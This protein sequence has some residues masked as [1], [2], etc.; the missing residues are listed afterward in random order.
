MASKERGRT[1]EDAAEEAV[2]HQSLTAEVLED[3]V[4][5]RWD[6]QRHLALDFSSPLFCLETLTG[7]DGGLLNPRLNISNLLTLDISYNALTE[8]DSVLSVQNGFKRLRTLKA[9]HNSIARADLE[10]P[11]LLSLD[12]SANQLQRLPRFEGIR[13]VQEL[14]LSRN[15]ISDSQL[16]SLMLLG[17]LHSLDLSYNNIGTLPSNFVRELNQLGYLTKL[18]KVDFRGNNCSA[19]FP[20]Y[21]T[22]LVANALE[23]GLHFQEIDGETI[24]PRAAKEI[25]ATVA[26]VLSKLDHFD[27]IYVERQEAA[28]S[29][30]Q[31][32]KY[33]IKASLAGEEGEASIHRLVALLESLIKVSPEEAPEVGAT[34]Y[35]VCCR[36]HAMDDAARIS[37]FWKNTAASE[38]AKNKA[39]RE[40]VQHA[41]LAV[42]HSEEARPLILRGIANLC[43]IP[44]GSVGYEVSVALSRLARQEFASQA[45]GDCG[46]QAAEVIAEIV[47]PSLMEVSGDE[48]VVMEVLTGLVAGTE[49]L[50]VALALSSCVP[51]LADLLTLCGPTASLCKVIAQVCLAEENC[52]EATGQGIPQLLCHRILEDKVP[53]D[54]Q[55][56][57]LFCDMC[58]IMGRCSWHSKKAALHLTKANMHTQIL[59]PLLREL[60]GER[61]DTCRLRI[62]QAK[63]AGAVIGALTGMIRNCEEAMNTCCNNYHLVDLLL[64]AVKEDAADPIILA[65]SCVGVRVILEN[66]VQR[67]EL[68]RYVTEELQGF[69]SLLQYLG[70]TRYVG[71]C[72]RAEL[73]LRDQDKLS[74]TPE[75][76][77]MHLGFQADNFMCVLV[78]SLA[79]ALFEAHREV[80]IVNVLA[81]KN[82]EVLFSAVECLN[83]I[84]VRFITSQTVTHLV[85]VLRRL[86]YPHTGL[87]S[88]VLQAVVRLLARLAA[89]DSPQAAGVLWGQRAEVTVTA[90]V[91]VIYKNLSTAR[92]PAR[93]STVE[94][95]HRLSKACI[96]LL[97]SASLVDSVRDIMRTKGV[98]SLF[99]PVLECEEKLATHPDGFD[100][101]LERTWTGRDVSILV[102]C[103]SGLNKLNVKKKVAFRV[104]C[105]LADIIEGWPDT[106]DVGKDMGLRALCGRE[107][108]MWDDVA[109]SR[110]LLSL[111]ERED[112]ERAPQQVDFVRLCV[113]ERLSLLLTPLVCKTTTHRHARQRALKQ[114]AEY[115]AGRLKADIE[116]AE[117]EIAR[118]EEEEAV[119]DDEDAA[120]LQQPQQRSQLRAMARGKP[121]TWKERLRNRNQAQQ[122]QRTAKAAP[123]KKTLDEELAEDPAYEDL[124]GTE[125]NVPSGRERLMQTLMTTDLDVDPN[126]AA[127]YLN[128]TIDM[129]GDEGLWA[130][131]HGAELQPC[132]VIAASL[133]VL[134]AAI[135]YPAD[136][137]IR[138]DTVRICRRIN[139]LRSFIALVEAVPFVA[140]NVAAKFCRLM[141]RVLQMEPHQQASLKE[142]LL[143]TRQ[144]M[145]P[146]HHL[147]RQAT[148]RPL[149]KKEQLL[150]V[151]L[152]GLYATIA[153]QIPYIKFSVERE[154]QDW[155]VEKAYERIFPSNVVQMFVAMLIMDLAIDSG[156]SHG[157]YVSHLMA[158]LGFQREKMRID[159]ICILAMLMQHCPDGLSYD[160]IEAL[161][162]ARVFLHH[163]IRPSVFY[164]LLDLTNTQYFRRTLE[165]LLSAHA[166]AAE[167]V[168][169]VAPV[170]WWN[171]L[172]HQDVEPVHHMAVATN[173]RF[174]IV[175]KPR[176]LREPLAPETEYA[177]E[178]GQG[179]KIVEIRDY[180]RMTR[181]VKGFP[182]DEWLAVGWIHKEG[183]SRVGQEIFDCLLCEVLHQADDMI[184]CLRACSGQ[185]EEE[186]VDVLRDVVSAECLMQHLK[187]GVLSTSSFAIRRTVERDSAPVDQLGLYV[188]TGMYLHEFFVDW[189]YWFAFDPAKAEE[190]WGVQLL[191]LDL[192]ADAMDWQGPRGGLGNFLGW[193]DP[194]L[195]R[196]DSSSA[197]EERAEAIEQGGPA[198]L[199]QM[200]GTE[201][202]RTLRRL[203][204]AK[205]C[206]YIPGV[207]H[208]L[209]DI[210]QIEFG[211]SEACWVHLTWRVPK[212]SRSSE[213]G[214]SSSKRKGPQPPPELKLLFLDDTSRERFRR[215]LAAGLNRTEESIH[216][217]DER[218]HPLFPRLIFELVV[219][220][221]GAFSLS[222]IFLLPVTRAGLFMQELETHL[223]VKYCRLNYIKA[224]PCMCMHLRSTRRARCDSSAQDALVAQGLTESICLVGALT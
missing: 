109:V 203:D 97:L 93:K 139:F 17:N 31:L 141:Q 36:V 142:F 136:A 169:Q 121:K 63:V 164:E 74:Y 223:E 195:E 171:A 77:C 129:Y 162:H 42:E 53:K 151:E 43:V 202:G 59:I 5:P 119:G 89:S 111:D 32:T 214:G 20:E 210:R 124:Y 218:G 22:V 28:A 189:K 206:L 94:N 71:M 150:C 132:Y 90:V 174:Y 88:S 18:T 19:W 197:Q 108:E 144:I 4:G 60:I 209:E 183:D 12:L 82:D 91:E 84:P 158:T 146:L 140:A 187:L 75:K 125:D 175:E 55:G 213:D 27:T 186:R 163:P 66:P 185:T 160:A 45:E 152:A 184:S 16:G 6:E 49:C 135:E 3:C 24:R 67:Q 107:A 95:M 110:R 211:G 98:V 176:G 56:L 30:P 115:W 198:W 104:L 68:L 204:A 51:L 39:A 21:A 191:C 216:V 155:A 46:G 177:Y 102:S 156:S 80:A 96:D 15:Q 9:C 70:G 182:G 114:H 179:I 147:V 58:L 57:M 29:Q 14:L 69:D 173:R 61:E 73:A 126:L 101:I 127:M 193:M 35:D 200:F 118:A 180:A 85:T 178:K 188:L 217:S 106:P 131:F 159:C 190:K 72:D 117:A 105:R 62:V 207:K 120:V 54:D 154:V 64:P 143:C 2:Q 38:R 37:T 112:S 157:T 220:W 13:N 78:F 47:V 170:L 205:Q 149:D 123:K 181:I 161:H 26:Y 81:V 92:W 199:R 83:S 34:F 103:L 113:S 23:R 8:I 215:A 212:H 145:L 50:A 133:R 40:M 137:V 10:L 79:E 222:A 196:L 224:G 116:D 165:L 130:N 48:R 100:V 153:R 52:L 86:P 194:E 208:K 168:L 138:A 219:G 201:Q 33:A 192:E 65:A 128:N 148:S 41:Q 134:Y 99:G 44:E 11:G 87:T 1:Q 122:Q 25:N 76:S 172:N 221:R 7:R 166:Q 167:R